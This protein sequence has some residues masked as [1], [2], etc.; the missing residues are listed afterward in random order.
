MLEPEYKTRSVPLSSLPEVKGLAV[1]EE[2]EESSQ[3]SP[4]EVGEVPALGGVVREPLKPLAA[5]SPELFRGLTATHIRLEDAR[6]RR[7]LGSF[8][9]VATLAVYAVAI[10]LDALQGTGMAEPWW[11]AAGPLA[12]YVLRVVLEGRARGEPGSS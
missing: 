7:L 1:V 8:V 9:L 12:G 10:V 3:A 11:A 4:D 5:R 2:E 6:H